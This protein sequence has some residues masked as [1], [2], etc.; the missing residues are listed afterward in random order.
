M[1]KSGEGEAGKSMKC[2]KCRGAISADDSIS[3]YCTECI[4]TMGSGLRKLSKEDLRR[5][6]AEV[7]IETAGL[8]S[9]EALKQMLEDMYDRMTS[10]EGFD[11]AIE[12]TAIQIQRYAGLGMAKEMLKV[13]QALGNMALEQEEEIRKKMRKLVTLGEKGRR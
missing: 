11:E 2:S 10:G 13:T 3:G 5:L 8:M 12:E 6:R 9:M 1:A 7:E 4:Q